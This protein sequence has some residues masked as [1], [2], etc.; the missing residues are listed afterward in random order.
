[1]Q[2]EIKSNKKH[3]RNFWSQLN[4]YLY[5]LLPPYGSLALAYLAWAVFYCLM[6]FGLFDRSL[7]IFLV[8][9][10]TLL[11][12]FNLLAL[13]VFCAAS[14]EP[15]SRHTPFLYELSRFLLAPRCLLRRWVDFSV[16][17]CLQT[18]LLFREIA[19][20]GLIEW[21]LCKTSI[22]RNRAQTLR[23]RVSA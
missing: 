22:H 13:G 21:C 2:K 11:V 14:N 1:M 17:L 4:T 16:Y 20:S 3:D 9:H 5:I 10:L 12:L 7:L 23:L 6:L 18:C 15:D 8:E 19:V